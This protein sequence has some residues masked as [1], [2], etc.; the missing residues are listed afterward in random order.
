MSDARLRG[1][2]PSIPPSPSS[3]QSPLLQL[4]DL[5]VRFGDKEVVRGVSF[6]IAAGE[7]LALVG[8][9]GS[10][11]T[12]TALSILRLAGDARI[13]GRALMDGHD[14]LA[15]S[16]REMRGVRGGDIAM[17]FQEPMTALNPLMSVGDQVAEVL[18]LKQALSRAQAGQAAI[19]LLAST[20]IPEPARRAGAFPHQL[21]GGQRQ[22]AMIS[23]ALASRPR[24]LLADE[25]TTALDVTL[26]GQILDLLSD[27]Q[28][29]TGMAVLL[30]THDLH[31]VRQFA[32]RVAVMEHG[33]LVESG[34]VSDVFR[35]P[36][37]AY[38]QRLI[39]SVPR[40]DVLDAAPSP[41]AVPAAQAHALR[42]AY[43]TP[44]PGIRGWF[45]RG[46]F[47]A[48]KGADFSIGPAR[49]LGVVGESGSGKSTLAQA[50]L[51][52]LPYQGELR[53]AGQ[54]WQLPAQRNTPEN[55]ALRRQVQVVFQ[56]PF[57]S[58]SPRLTVEEI[59]GEGLRVHEPG[60][61]PADRRARVQSAL[62]DV[63]LTEAQ[64][65]GL[66]AR[67]PHEFSGGQRQ[68][69]AIARALILS[70]R[71][72]V[73]DEP[74]SALD[75]TI[76]QQVLAL[77]QRLQKERSLSYLLITHDVAVIRAMA[78][79]VIVMK[80]GEVLES[81]PVQAVLDAPGHPYTQRLVSAAGL[82]G[83]G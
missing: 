73:L 52:L 57:S 70:P 28:R 74:T 18:Q 76:Q 80:D 51:G 60:L 37:H 56:D 83:V 48:V 11:K 7:K 29:Q 39:G 58:L 17:V 25:P 40:R 50:L 79:D 14:L 61:S 6:D 26:R 49:T 41:T 64:F 5:R 43:A 65:P 3:P 19:E 15:L 54:G 63:G 23:M 55:Q 2:A 27:L 62:E 45:R 82:D 13:T 1:T 33:V 47:V 81:G 24:L 77:L 44:L 34:A 68:R 10:G 75:V 8:E 30:I 67:Y 46:E 16:E 22:R 59:V 53:I 21:S 35:A 9:S 36:Q 71:L 66:L 69:L 4:Q 20:G 78:H 31:L 42:V 38:T 72:L 12:I 32:D